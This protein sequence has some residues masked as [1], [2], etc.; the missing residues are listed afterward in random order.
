MT[1]T[2]QDSAVKLPR[3]FEGMF[4][5]AFRSHFTVPKK[6]PLRVVTGWQPCDSLGFRCASGVLN[7]SAVIYLTAHNDGTLSDASVIDETITP[8]LADSLRSALAAMSRA[9]DVPPTGEAETITLAL[10]VA[11]QELADSGRASS[12]LF[13]AVVPHYAW[14]FN[15]A[16]MPAAGVKASYPLRARLAGVEDSVAIA[17]TVDA[18]GTI[19]PESL[20][21]V[22]ANYR[23][24]VASVVSALIKVRYHAAHLGDCAVATRM[25]QRFVFK[26]PQ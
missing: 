9:H 11:P 2:A 16:T 19:V 5:E 22:S 15:S 12:N 4:V 17:F 18:D 10:K 23:E 7:L 24:F 8:A 26:A 20:D 1:I 14:P 25:K 13:T 3:D 21:L 6:L